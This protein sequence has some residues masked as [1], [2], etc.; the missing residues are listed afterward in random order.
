M[1]KCLRAV[2]QTEGGG[3][4]KC[5]GREGEQDNEG[6]R[7]DT[8]VGGNCPGYVL[9]YVIQYGDSENWTT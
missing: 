1:L 3:K 5:D 7:Q 9:C 8:T 2:T 6:L 4:K